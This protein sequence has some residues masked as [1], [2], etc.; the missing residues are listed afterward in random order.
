MKKRIQDLADVISTAPI[1]R[2]KEDFTIGTMGEQ[3]KDS[4]ITEISK[5]ILENG[6]IKA[7]DLFA[8]LEVLLRAKETPV[9]IT[10]LLDSTAY[11]E[12]QAK[13]F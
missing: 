2:V 8:D 11:K 10:A 12:F 3:F 1:G 13:Y 7:A 4:F 5:H 9:C 6:Y